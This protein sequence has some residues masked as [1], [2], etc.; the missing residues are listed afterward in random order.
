MFGPVYYFDSSG[1][2]LRERRIDF[3]ALIAV[4]RTGNQHPG[5]SVHWPLPDGS[6]LIETIP[7]DWQ[8]PA[9]PGQIYRRPT[10]YVRIDSAYSAHAFGW[11]EGRERLSSGLENLPSGVPVPAQAMTVAG[12]NPPSVYATN[13]DRY[14]VHQ[15][16]MSGVLRRILRRTVDPIA[17]P[18]DEYEEWQEAMQAWNPHRDWRRW[19]RVMGGLSRRYHP[20]IRSFW[21]DSEGFLWISDCWN[22]QPGTTEWSV[23]TR[24]GAGWVLSHC[25]A[26][27]SSGSE[28]LHPRWSCRLRYGTADCGALPAGPAVGEVGEVAAPARIVGVATPGSAGR[29]GPSAMRSAS[30][31]RWTRILPSTPS[32]WTPTRNATA[33]T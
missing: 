20:A 29:F 9:E 28:R 4:T 11:W 13:G 15:F 27:T 21:V 3:G 12:G 33:T 17:L 25:L 23:L 1:K 2:L 31:P 10:G 26:Q 19:E 7:S 6:F 8:P 14:E 18:D 30:W 22:G 16:S 32:S 24:R 5:E